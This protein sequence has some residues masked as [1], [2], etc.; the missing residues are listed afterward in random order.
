MTVRKRREDPEQTSE[1]T[2]SPR[3]ADVGRLLEEELSPLGLRRK[4]LREVT[5]RAQEAFPTDLAARQRLAAEIRIHAPT[6]SPPLS[7][8]TNPLLSLLRARIGTDFT[9]R[10]EK[11][12]DQ[13][14]LA[15][16]A[17]EPASK[18][19]HVIWRSRYGVRK[20]RLVVPERNAGSSSWSALQVE[21]WLRR[22]PFKPKIFTWGQPDLVRYLAAFVDAREVPAESLH[23]ELNAELVDL[24]VVNGN[25]LGSGQ[26]HTLQELL[27]QRPDPPPVVIWCGRDAAAWTLDVPADFFVVTETAV[28]GERKRPAPGRGTPLVTGPLL[29]RQSWT[30]EIDLGQRAPC[31]VVLTLRSG[32]AA[33]TSA[34]SSDR[35]EGYVRLDLPRLPALRPRPSKNTPEP[36][37]VDEAVQALVLANNCL[38]QSLSFDLAQAMSI[39]CALLCPEAVGLPAPLEGAPC[40][41]FTSDDELD[42]LLGD[43]NALRRRAQLSRRFARERLIPRVIASKVL[44]HVGLPALISRAPLVSVICV[45]NRPHLFERCVETYSRQTY[46]RKELILVANVAV[47]G[48]SLLELLEQR[49]DVL[50]LRTDAELSLGESL[51]R[52]RAAAQGDVWTKFDDDDYYGAHY[53]RDAVLALEASEADVCGKGT[54]YSYLEDGDELYVT[55]EAPENSFSNRYVH[56]GTI[57]ARRTS[58]DGIDFPPVQRGTDTLFLQQCAL[59]EKRIYSADRYNFA[60]IR[61][62]RPGHHT[63]DVAHRRY[64]KNSRKIAT[65]FR[66]DLIEI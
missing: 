25:G 62:H 66:R 6:G 8:V 28:S 60:Y 13:A 51:N 48:P 61:Y 37:R 20:H 5:T 3:P 58:T 33:T 1:T 42:A 44:A 21:S 43:R 4:V 63:F 38:P 29:D 46:Q 39:G 57:L 14:F 45:S 56:G 49:S 10:L 12:L 15:E 59:L 41:Q 50:L 30:S 9:S 19:G 22:G 53:L 35:P 7:Q 64:L 40:Q 31:D 65:G 18:Y 23:Q 52:A 17:A 2:G 55:P 47:I 32:A 34:P 36:P 11:K 24:I 26:L 27:A 54:F 16:A